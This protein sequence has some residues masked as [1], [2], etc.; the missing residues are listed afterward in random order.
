M[1]AL[2]GDDPHARQHR[3][4]RVPVEGPEKPARHGGHV[5]VPDQGG[6]VGEGGDED[7]VAREVEEGGGEG[8]LEAVAGHGG[9]DVGE[10]EGRGRQGQGGGD[11]LL[12]E[13]VA[14][15]RLGI[16]VGGWVGGWRLVGGVGGV[17]RLLPM[18]VSRE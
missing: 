18:F 1:P 11:G 4:L 8:A 7:E 12:A 15:G 9:L 14:V 3:P 2:V 16:G 17:D 13:D 10:R 6:Q 5:V